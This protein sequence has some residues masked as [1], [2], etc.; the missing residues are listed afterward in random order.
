MNPLQRKEGLILWLKAIS[1]GV[2][3]G[4]VAHEGYTILRHPFKKNTEL[5]CFCEI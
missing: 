2:D 1:S 3:L 5:S 4:F